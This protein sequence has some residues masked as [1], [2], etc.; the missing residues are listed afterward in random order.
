ML[1]KRCDIQGLRGWAII[2]VILFHFYPEYFP[3]GYLGVDVFLVLSGFL[4]TMILRRSET[5]N[6]NTFGVFYYRRLVFQ[7]IL[8][9]YL[10]CISCTTVAI[11]L[12]LPTSYRKLNATY[13]RQAFLLTTNMHY[14]SEMEM[15]YQ[16]MVCSRNLFTHTWSLCLE[17]Q[18]YLIVPFLF[19]LQKCITKRDKLFILSKC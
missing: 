10:L 14:S 15:D 5:L 3:N 2:L 4:V 18:W 17:M 19:L 12:I 13:A 16:I 6:L 11:H 8:P 1:N 7:R 9:L